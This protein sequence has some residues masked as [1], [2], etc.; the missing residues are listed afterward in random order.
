M[1]IVN[2]NRTSFVQVNTA[3]QRVQV[4]GGRVRIADTATPSAD[5]WQVW[6]EGVVVDI[7]TVKF[8]QAV[9]STPTWLV[10]QSA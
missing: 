4:F 3:A 8:A 1:T 7:V 2:L 9:D 5:D 10:V 6:P